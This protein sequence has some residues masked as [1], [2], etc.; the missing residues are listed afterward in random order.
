MVAP[1]GRGESEYEG[2]RL[3]RVKMLAESAEVVF[4]ASV[5]SDRLLQCIAAQDRLDVLCIHHAVVGDYRSPEFDVGSAVRSATEGARPITAAVAAKGATATMLTRSVFEA[6]QGISDDPRAIGL[7]AVAKSAT[8]GVW[9][10]H[11]RESGLARAEFTITNPFGPYEE[12][13]LV[14][15]LAR[16]G[17]RNTPTPRAPWWVRDNIP[18]LLM[19]A[20][21]AVA[22][23][24][25]RK[26]Q[27]SAACRATWLRRI[28]NMRGASE[29]SS[30]AAGRGRAR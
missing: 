3:Q 19:A 8:V 13:R 2:V 5:G 10:E 30:R 12:P 29:T 22:S 6:G 4:G 16:P 9:G 11:A 14:D 25:P 1:L 23:S 24:A 21:Y 27:L 18:V 7:Y 28:S 15:F 26:E 20:D 17:R